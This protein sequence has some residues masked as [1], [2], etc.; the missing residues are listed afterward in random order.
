[1]FNLGTS[2]T[3]YIELYRDTGSKSLSWTYNI[4]QKV[5]SQFSHLKLQKLVLFS[6]NKPLSYCPDLLRI[7]ECFSV[8]LPDT[9]IEVQYS[10][11]GAGL[12]WLECSRLASKAGNVFFSLASNESDLKIDSKGVGQEFSLSLG[13]DDGGESEFTK[14]MTANGAAFMKKADDF[15]KGLKAPT[16]SPETISISCRSKKT[17]AIVM[18]A[19][20][21][22]LPCLFFLSHL[23]G[24]YENT[25]LRS[26]VEK[27]GG[28]DSL[29]V[30]RVD[31]ETILLSDLYQNALPAHWR[32]GQLGKKRLKIC[33][34]ACGQSTL[35]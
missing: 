30:D 10:D 7:I 17:P 15:F 19:D 14:L 23:S 11:Q 21:T 25:H 22:V 2:L 13:F 9:I 24:D 26:L 12:A 35:T 8:Q 32:Q 28:L 31:L 33:S 27:Y 1:M 29:K 20:Y 6:S 18:A 16:E 4:V 3:V 5:T 34:V